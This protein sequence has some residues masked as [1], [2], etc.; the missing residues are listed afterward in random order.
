MIKT[1]LG[2]LVIDF[3]HENTYL[4]EIAKYS[5]SFEIECVRF[6]PTSIQPTTLS[7]DGERFDSSTQQWK[8]ASFPIPPFIYDRCF[9][10]D[11]SLAKKSKP[12]VT[13][14]KSYPQTTFLGF[15][16]PN[17]W[18]VY[19]ALATNKEIEPYLPKSERIYNS[20][21][22]ETMLKETGSC[23]L[24]PVKGS[25][26]FGIYFIRQ[27]PEQL[28]I[29][30][31]HG[32]DKKT[33]TFRSRNAF[34]RW[35]NTL[36]QNQ[37]YFMQPLLSLTDEEGYPFDLR[38]FLQKDQ[39]GAWH[40]VDKAIRKGYQGS[41]LSNLSSGGDPITYKSWSNHLASKQKYLLEDELHTIASV[42]PPFLEETFQPLFELGIDIGIAKDG[43]IW[44]LDINSKPGRKT[45]VTTNPSLTEL[46]H[47][48]PLYYCIYLVK[49]MSETKTTT[50]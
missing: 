1:T 21:S 39:N 34:H 47:Q 6:T 15:G 32:R 17:K 13:W 46:F 12:I 37:A 35:C 41:F 45:F 42:L 8:K 18:D 10:H 26:G 19:S 25:R 3:T 14:L 22:I 49:N 27:E 30:Y 9:Y 44:I 36:I 50:L 48:A 4:T 7:I 16:L 2:F 20:L 11:I 38:L 40:L 29:T 24:K 23:I 31:H 5:D 43:S 28:T 33:K